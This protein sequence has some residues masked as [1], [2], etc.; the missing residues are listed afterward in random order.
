MGTIKLSGFDPQQAGDLNA[1]VVDALHGV[2]GVQGFSVVNMVPFGEPAAR[3]G[4][5]FDQEK[6]HFGG[7]IDFYVGDAGAIEAFGLRLLAG[8]FPSPDEYTV[9]TQNVP[10]NPPVLI[11]RALAAHFWPGRNPVGQQ[12]RAMDTTFRVIGVI[13]HLS[14]SQPGAGESEDPDWTVFVPALAGENLAGTYLIRGRQAVQQITGHPPLSLCSLRQGFHPI[15]PQPADPAAWVAEALANH[16]LINAGS[17]SVAGAQERIDAAR[18]ANLPTL[19]LAFTT[20]HAPLDS[21]TPGPQATYSTVGLQLTIPLVAGGAAFAAQKQA[22]YN[23]DASVA[24]LEATRRSVVR[25]VEAQWQAAQ[26]SVNDI[27]NAEAAALAAE[28]ALAATRTG[29]LLGTPSLTD[30]LYAIQTNGQAQLQLTQAR[31][32]HVVA[33]LLLKQAAG[34][35]SIDDLVSINALL[36]PDSGKAMGTSP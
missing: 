24:Q 25:N 21:L 26:G 13:D 19:G 35:L 2:A 31:H 3:A 18:A 10:I 29:Q 5:T 12:I 20:E 6:K 17:A 14:V 8:R 7:V 22:G 11:T 33:M 15:G 16:P 23:R 9:V 34:R 4:V 30:V 36:E 27:A 28:R 1:R 32:R